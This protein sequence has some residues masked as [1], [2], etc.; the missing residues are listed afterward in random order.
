MTKLPEID[1]V[2]EL[3]IPWPDSLQGEYGS[4]TTVMARRESDLS[5][6]EVAEQRASGILKQLYQIVEF[7]T[8]KIISFGGERWVYDFLGLDIT[9]VGAYMLP[10]GEH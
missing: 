4:S 10:T 7:D 9:F 5:D 3:E 1:E 8:H 6:V 2:F